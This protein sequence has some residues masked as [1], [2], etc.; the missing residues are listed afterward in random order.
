M[1]HDATGQT[2]IYFYDDEPQRRSVNKRLT[3]T[4]RA[5]DGQL[6]QAAG[7][8]CRSVGHRRAVGVFVFRIQELKPLHVL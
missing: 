7:L 5:H 3:R 6:R 2:L 8:L 1:V 4:T